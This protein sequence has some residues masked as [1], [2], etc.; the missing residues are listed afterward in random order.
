MTIA[1]W[2]GYE[3]KLKV[4]FLVYARTSPKRNLIN[5]QESINA[6]FANLNVLPTLTKDLCPLNPLKN[7]FSSN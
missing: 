6:P 5:E 7:V 3:V 4:N 1:D 2:R